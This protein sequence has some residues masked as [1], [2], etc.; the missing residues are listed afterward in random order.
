MKI[1]NGTDQKNTDLTSAENSNLLITDDAIIGPVKK[2]TD[3]EKKGD[4]A[5]FFSS[6]FDL[7]SPES[8]QITARP[9]Q[10]GVGSTDAG[11]RTV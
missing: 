10:R 8:S 4:G 3:T 9:P 11:D 6:G 1:I 5:R 2:K 7:T